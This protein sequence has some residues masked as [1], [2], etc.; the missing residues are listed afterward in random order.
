MSLG[1]ICDTTYKTLKTN[2]GASMYIPLRNGIKLWLISQHI[3]G[4]TITSIA[5]MPSLNQRDQSQNY[6]GDVSRLA[7]HQS[8]Q[9]IVFVNL[10]AFLG[11][12]LSGSWNPGTWLAPA[13]GGVLAAGTESCSFKKENFNCVL[14]VRVRFLINHLGTEPI[15]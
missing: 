14:F 5:T 13:A 4:T 9:L 15:L 12:C 6:K 10:L 3:V 7:L 8:S 1:H 11:I 2:P